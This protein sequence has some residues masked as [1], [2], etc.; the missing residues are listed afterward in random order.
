[1]T[2]IEIAKARIEQQTRIIEL[3]IIHQTMD[4][5]KQTRY[6]QTGTVGS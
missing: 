1:M 5:E 4:S 6:N 3:S 2:Q